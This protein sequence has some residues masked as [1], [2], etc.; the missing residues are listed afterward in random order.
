MISE[1]TIKWAIV[2][3]TVLG[4]LGAGAAWIDNRFDSV[5]D[6]YIVGAM[7]TASFYLLIVGTLPSDTKTVINEN[8]E[9]RKEDIKQ[10]NQEPDDAIEGSLMNE[11]GRDND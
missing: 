10:E 5:M 1:R 6:A 11:L 3:S 4:T 9:Y 7:L 8:Y 2:V